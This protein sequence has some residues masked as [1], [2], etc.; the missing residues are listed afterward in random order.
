MHARN[1]QPPIEFCQVELFDCTTVRRL[2]PARMEAGR[3]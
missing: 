2:R 3:S 1:A